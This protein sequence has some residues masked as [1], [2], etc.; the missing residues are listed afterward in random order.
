MIWHNIIFHLH[1]ALLEPSR[2]SESDTLWQ[3]VGPGLAQSESGGGRAPSRWLTI[4]WRRAW[5]LSLSQGPGCLL[6]LWDSQPA[7][8]RPVPV[9][10][11]GQQHWPGLSGGLQV[12]NYLVTPTVTRPDPP[13]Q[14][15]SSWLMG[16]GTPA[17]RTR[18]TRASLG[19]RVWV[20]VTSSGMVTVTGLVKAQRSGCS[21]SASE[22][23]REFSSLRVAA[24]D[25]LPIVH[26]NA[27]GRRRRR[28]LKL[29]KWMNERETQRKEQK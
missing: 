23:P 12:P 28:R 7:R 17:R 20:T 3:C 16:T 24:S 27:A 21:A 26:H 14:R 11:P 25:Y 13:A 4:S 22:A 10:Q 1:Q 15:L 6:W 9:P 5:A 29:S 2:A 19:R 18:L 8:R